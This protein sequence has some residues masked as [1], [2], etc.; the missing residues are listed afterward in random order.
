MR[1]VPGT[2]GSAIKRGG[3]GGEGI[4]KDSVSIGASRRAQMFKF[5]EGNGTHCLSTEVVVVGAP[6]SF[7]SLGAVHSN[8]PGARD[9]Q[10]RGGGVPS[11]PNKCA[12]RCFGCVCNTSSFEEEITHAVCPFVFQEGAE[13]TEDF[14]NHPLHRF[15]IPGSKNFQ[16]LTP[17]SAA[18]HLS[19]LPQE[20]ITSEKIMQLF[21]QYGEVKSFEYFT[22]TQ[23]VP[24]VPFNA[25]LD[26]AT[27]VSAV[28]AWMRPSPSSLKPCPCGCVH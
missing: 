8:A 12:S 1:Q 13:L 19:N 25:Q 7:N 26:W 10:P 6:L 15:R 17:P 3:V 21:S 14:A 23:K 28:G 18:L 5:L 16:H 4:L 24:A 9:D 22:N 27:L 20:G 2:T 11:K